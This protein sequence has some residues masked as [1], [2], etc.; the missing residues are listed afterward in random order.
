MKKI[1]VLA[2]ALMATTAA[3]AQVSF[4]FRAGV[5]FARTDMSAKEMSLQ[6]SPG[7]KTGFYAGPV[8]DFGLGKNFA[9]RAELTYNLE[10]WRCKFNDFPLGEMMSSAIGGIIGGLPD[11]GD[12]GDLG[13]LGLLAG[14]KLNGAMYAHYHNLRLPVMINFRP[15]GGLS[16]M[17]GPYVSYRI[18]VGAGFSGDLKTLVRATEE[19]DGTSYADDLKTSVKEN[20]KAFDLGLAFGLE[21]SFDMGVFFEPRYTLGLLNTAKSDTFADS[22]MSLTPRARNSA[23]Q[24]G[25]GVKF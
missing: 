4:G 12:L 19:E 5:G 15:V 16:I 6:M 7:T 25:M 11:A 8:A 20:Y 18:A 1:A 21:Y 23:I 13:D 17:A 3:V 9:I 14:Y 24:I 10:G 2:V 22:G